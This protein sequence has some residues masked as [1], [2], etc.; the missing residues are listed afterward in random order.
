MDK[1][2]KAASSEASEAATSTI[3]NGMFWSSV[4]TVE[5]LRLADGK[6]IVQEKCIGK[7]SKS[8]SLWKLLIYHQHKKSPYG[9]ME[10][11]TDRS[12]RSRLC[13]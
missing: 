9:Q 12:T 5:L 3:L 2:T 6:Y 1:A 10:N 7:C 8:I 13:A 4:E 11:V